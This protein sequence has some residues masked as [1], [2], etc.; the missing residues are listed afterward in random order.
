MCSICVRF[1]TGAGAGDKR[2]VPFP[3]EDHLNVTVGDILF[4]DRGP[5][6]ARPSLPN[7]LPSTP[8][9]PRTVNTRPTA[10]IIPPPKRRRSSSLSLPFTLSKSLAALAPVTR[11][12]LQD[13]ADARVGAVGKAEGRLLSGSAER[14]PAE[15][16]RPHASF[17]FCP[18][19]S[20]LAN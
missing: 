10:E 11:G 1:R 12:P 6:S 7:V 17:F 8:I 5:E 4:C 9:P 19:Y 2:A 14:G 13:G 15:Q 16:V 20:R 3:T 18:T